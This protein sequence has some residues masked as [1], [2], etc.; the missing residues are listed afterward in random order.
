MNTIS[1][2]MTHRYLAVLDFE[3]NCLRGRVHPHQEIT[4]FPVIVFDTEA[5][6]V[7]DELTFHHYC[8]IEEKLTPFATELTGITQEQV[9]AG[10]PFKEVMKEFG[11][12]MV[13][14]EMYREDGTPNVLFLTY[15]DW[16]LQTALPKQCKYSK[17]KVPSYFRTWGNVKTYFKEGYGEKKG[18]GMMGMLEFLGIKHVGRHHSGI[19]DCRNIMQIVIHMLNEGVEIHPTT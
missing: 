9:D 10:M 14:N 2:F 8:R 15:G 4:E 6:K 19:D 13:T 1:V 3:A 5:R 11:Q 7:R 17:I 16:D 12:W 18:P